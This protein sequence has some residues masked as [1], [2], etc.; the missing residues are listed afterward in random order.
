MKARKSK[1]NAHAYGV[2]FYSYMRAKGYPQYQSESVDEV[3]SPRFFFC[4]YFRTLD[5]YI[6]LLLNFKKS[7]K[8]FL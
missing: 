2:G 8:K 4:L 3:I 5:Y 1:A 7:W 6:Y